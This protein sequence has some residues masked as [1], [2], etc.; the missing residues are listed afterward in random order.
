MAGFTMVKHLLGADNPVTVDLVI[1]NSQTI[2]VGDAIKMSSGYAAVCDA[3]DRIF[4][5]VVGI[6]DNNGIDLQNTSASNYDGTYTDGGVG[7]GTYVAAADNATDKKVKAKV[8]ADPYALFENTAD[9]AME[10]AD[11]GQHFSLV[12]EDQ[13]DAST[14]SATV[15]EMQL[16]AMPDGAGTSGQFRISSW[17]GTAFEPET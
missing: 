11:L 2:T 12:D 3:N 1:A 4:G 8:V 13:I 15:G 14:N 9:G 10:L 5:I 16:W 6:V 7:V 17:Q